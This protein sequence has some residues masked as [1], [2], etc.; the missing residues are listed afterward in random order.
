MKDFARMIRRHF[1]EIVAYFEHPYTNAVLKGADSVIRTSNDG[2]GLPQHGLLRHHDLPDL[3]QTRPQS[4]HHHL[5]ITHHK[6][7][8]AKK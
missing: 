6:Q 1:A 7:R 3:R 5:T 8:I 4:R 2:R